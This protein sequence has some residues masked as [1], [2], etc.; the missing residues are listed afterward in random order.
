MELNPHR[1]RWVG[2]AGL[3]VGFLFGVAACGVSDAPEDT[4]GLGGGLADDDDAN[5]CD[6]GISVI[7]SDYQ[8][9]AVA[10]VDWK[11]RVISPRVI[12][13]G[14]A[15]V[16]LSAPL[17]GDVV[18]PTTATS[19]AETAMLDRGPASVVTW[20][21]LA[22]GKPRAQLSVRTGFA[23]NLQD[24]VQIGD[25]LGFVTRLDPNATP[26]REPFDG[27]SDVL[28][29]DPRAPA[30][31]GRIGL[32][33][34]LVGEDPTLLAR[35]SRLLVA[36][37]RLVVLLGVLSSDFQAA[38]DARVV[39]IDTKTLAVSEIVRLEGL[40]N[41]QAMA[42]APSRKGVAD[43]IA[44][45]CTG[46]V[47]LDGTTDIDHGGVAVVTL[48]DAETASTVANVVPATRFG[49]SPQFSI[50]F[51]TRSYVLFP[52]FGTDPAEGG[53]AHG[54]DLVLLDVGSGESDVV[55][56]SAKAFEL[57]EVRCASSCGTCFV[58]DAGEGAVRRLEFDEGYR[59][60]AP[61][62]IDDGI[63]LPPRFLGA[64]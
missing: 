15:D 40:Q 54:D 17:S 10:F 13:S 5:E 42:L 51:A 38:G 49:R 21:D 46:R 43:R 45:G 24:Y 22:T 23:A 58:A 6:R 47:E 53:E 30:I 52:T 31:T 61:V 7:S 32:E 28:V 14:S 63:G 1:G 27:G 20:I 9:T 34:A 36:G 62:R 37:G 3:L 19:K 16:A 50:G 60:V 11:G 26:G 59:V 4:G 29:V 12:T 2:V 25:D 35:P 8:S 48:G 57:G 44:V 41:C 39:V 18:A 55:L 33:D 56:T 64:L